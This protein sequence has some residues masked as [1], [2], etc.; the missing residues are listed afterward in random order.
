ME[1]QVKSRE[2]KF[3]VHRPA[4]VDPVT[5]KKTPDYHWIKERINYEDGTSEDNFR[6][7][8][9]FKRPFWITQEHKRNHKQKKELENAENLTCYQ[10][11]ES[12]LWDEVAKVLGKNG[13]LANPR[14]LRQCPYLYGTD[15]NSRVFIKKAYKKKYPDAFS[16][17]TVATLDIENDIDTGEITI[18]SISREWEVYTV[19]LQKYLHGIS[20]PIDRLKKIFKDNIPLEQNV[21]NTYEVCPDEVTM[22]Y[23]IMMKAHEWA[24]DFLAIWNMD[25]ELSYF[26]NLCDKHELRME[27]FFSDPSVPPELRFF[28]YKKKAEVK[29]SVSGKSKN[30]DVQDRW[31]VVYCPAKFY[32]IDAMCAYNYVRVNSKKVPTGYG[33]DS[34]LGHELGDKFKK[35]K[36]NNLN[37]NDLVGAD[38]HRYMVKYHP[39]EYVVYNQWDVLSMLV[40]E[41]KTKDLKVS[42]P[43]LSGVSTFDVFDSGPKRVVNSLMFT[44][45]EK[46]KVL[47]TRM[48][49]EDIPPELDTNLGLEG[50]IVTLSASRLGENNGL[51]VIEEDPDMIST[52]YTHVFDADQVSGYPS[53]TMEV[54]VSR[55]TTF[56]EPI[57]FIGCDFEVARKEN[58]NL[59]FGPVSHL[60][61]GQMLLNM[62]TVKEVDEFIRKRL[63]SEGKL[64]VRVEA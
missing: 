30:S 36:F 2:C 24:P 33:L 53:N 44:G 9:D 7:L 15:I 42:V 45:L 64:K 17:Y 22:F 62:P 16:Y 38:W 11:T 3:I 12:E 31:N 48:N 34:I 54:N 18:I 29:V 37:D 39:L 49:K 43:T 5:Q 50:W 56:R 19:I 32:V 13:M 28:T 21:I 26:K 60:Q 25:H 51:R 47:G 59:M 4:T 46:G 6:V 35:L 40:L 20:N 1:K 8:K 52:I 41:N 55:T 58:I 57:Q 27:D 23:K 10:A 61:Y 63:E 14:F